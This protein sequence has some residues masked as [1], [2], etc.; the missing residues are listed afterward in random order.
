MARGSTSC[1]PNSPNPPKKITG[2]LGYFNN[3]PPPCTDRVYSIS[4]PSSIP[5]KTRT[6]IIGVIGGIPPITPIILLPNLHSPA[7]IMQFP[8]PV[9]TESTP[10]FFFHQ[11]I[12]PY[13]KQKTEKKIK[14]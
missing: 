5:N 11:P 13:Q 10:S 7:F 3:H 9:Q 14:K 1:L 12:T 6:K 2:Q 8:P 4:F